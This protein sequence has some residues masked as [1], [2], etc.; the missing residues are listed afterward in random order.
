[1]S[2]KNDVLFIEENNKRIEQIKQAEPLL[3]HTKIHFAKSVAEA[4]KV[5]SSLH[6]IPVFITHSSPGLDGLNVTKSLISSFPEISVTIM[7]DI[8]ITADQNDTSNDHVLML[9]KPD[10]TSDFALVIQQGILT[11]RS[12]IRTALQVKSV[13]DEKNEMEHVTRGIMK[14]YQDLSNIV[15]CGQQVQETMDLNECFKIIID[16]LHKLGL[17][18]TITLNDD[19]NEKKKIRQ[20]SA[21]PS[22]HFQITGESARIYF[23]DHKYAG[24]IDSRSVNG[25]A[26]DEDRLSDPFHLIRNQLLTFLD[27]FGRIEEREQLLIGYKGILSKLEDILKNADFSRK[28][29]KVKK[30]LENDS[31]S[32]FN[33]LDKIREKV[34]ADVIPWVEEVEISLQFADRV[35]QQINSLTSILR[36]L[37]STINPE[38]SDNIESEKKESTQSVLDDSAS[39]QSSVDDL[40]ESL[41]M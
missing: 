18:C 33:I 7:T 11:H 3:E 8:M 9:P 15:H 10:T 29:Q 20:I 38:L 41:G 25:D 17:D 30:E 36:E 22:G 34:S 27:R 5:L 40:L 2:A 12:K 21:D 37:L 39:E 19:E 14:S 26:F 13:S 35:S 32:I 28:A 16:A 31:E 6:D 24:H 23:A 4:I 1:M